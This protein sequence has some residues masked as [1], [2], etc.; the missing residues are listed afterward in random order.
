MDVAAVVAELVR[1]QRV[2]RDV[3]GRRRV[4]RRTLEVLG[5]PTGSG[6]TSARPGVHPQ[7]WSPVRARRAAQQAERVGVH[8][9]GRTDADARRGVSVGSW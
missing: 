9:L 3:T 7:V 6:R 4:A 5:E 2:E 8:D 1:A